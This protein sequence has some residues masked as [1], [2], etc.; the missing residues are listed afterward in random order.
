MSNYFLNNHYN[1]CLQN[2]QKKIKKIPPFNLKDI[3]QYQKLSPWKN[4]QPFY[5]AFKE[6][7]NNKFKSLKPVVGY[8][9][10]SVPEELISA[11]GLTPLRLDY[12]SL[13]ASHNSENLVQ[14]EICPVIKSIVG[15]SNTN[16]YKNIELVIVPAT[17]EGKSKLA[18]LIGLKKEIYFLNLPK[19]NDYL[20]NKENWLKSYQD[21]LNYLIKKFQVKFKKSE[22]LEKIN[23]YNQ[24]TDI[25]RELF[26]FRLKHPGIIN[27]FDYFTLTCASFFM[28]PRDWLT[29]TK[30]LL[31]EVALLKNSSKPKIKL[32]FLGSPIFFPEFKIL[33]ILEELATDISADILC[34]A[35]GHLYEPVIVNETNLEQLL[36][37]LTQKH[38][39]GNYCPCF[40]KNLE[41]FVDLIINLYKENELDGIIYYNLRLCQPYDI[42][43]SFIKPILKAHQIPCLFLKSD[44]GKEDLG[45][46]KTRIEAFLE[47]I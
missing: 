43:A 35:Y 17:C 23:L 45:Q 31:T 47:V 24:R 22:L 30:K 2:L 3:A 9:C 38:L 29:K 12:Y 39:A 21:L 19:T 27:S 8:F 14:A 37:S 40:N 42:F 26:A 15:I 10:N 41:K 11:C 46:L 33:K 28:E 7:T 1:Q 36:L 32:L 25:F 44:L 18:E 4:S 34:S 16:L 6:L 13:P 5:Q 20:V